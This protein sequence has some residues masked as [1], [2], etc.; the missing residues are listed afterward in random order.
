MFP[1]HT[2]LPDAHTQAPIRVSN[3]CCSVTETRNIRVYKNHNPMLPEVQQLGRLYRPLSSHWH[4]LWSTGLSGTKRHE[5]INKGFLVAHMGFCNARNRY[6]NR[7]RNKRCDLWHGCSR[8]NHWNALLPRRLNERPIPHSGYEQAR[9]L[10]VSA[11]RM[12]WISD[13]APWL[14]CLP[15][16]AGFWG[17]F[18]AILASYN[19]ASILQRPHSGRT[20]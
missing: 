7:F 10:L 6:P 19:P 13:F 18:P 11:P 20:W 12:G 4:Y 16:L 3:S 5:T 2:W 14:H 17:E 15:G 8:P 1:F 9:G